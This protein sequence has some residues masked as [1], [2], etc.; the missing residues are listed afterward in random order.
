M[1]EEQLPPL[2]RNQIVDDGRLKIPGGR[3]FP[4]SNLPSG[5]VMA[6]ALR[7]AMPDLQV[8]L[9]VAVRETCCGLF[10]SFLLR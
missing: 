3:D 1:E 2:D 8:W 6:D 9:M 5:H 7:S 10:F 4:L